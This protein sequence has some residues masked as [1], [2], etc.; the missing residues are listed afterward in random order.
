MVQHDAGLRMCPRFQAGLK[1]LSRRRLDTGGEIA[2]RRKIQP[3]KFLSNEFLTNS[4]VVTQN[5]ISAL[6]ILKGLHSTLH[7]FRLFRVLGGFAVSGHGRNP[8][9]CGL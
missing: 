5:H 7:G 6:S 2:M 8:R 3:L 9:F 4:S 1:F